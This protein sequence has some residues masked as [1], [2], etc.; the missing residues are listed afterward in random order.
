MPKTFTFH[1]I[2]DIRQRHSF[3]LL[4]YAITTVKIKK[5]HFGERLY[6]F[7]KS[8]NLQEQFWPISFF[9]LAFFSSVMGT[10]E[11]IMS[12]RKDFPKV[13]KIVGRRKLFFVQP[14]I[15]ELW[16]CCHREI[17][18][19]LRRLILYQI[20]RFARHFLRLP[21]YGKQHYHSIQKWKNELEM[22]FS[23]LK[24]FS[25]SW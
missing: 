3:S 25:S 6:F 2:T 17:K 12:R 15:T 23:V 4:V 24:V 18:L 10:F 20:W 22:F 8:R 16:C 1:S 21:H 9:F 19:W 5:S 14:I 13:D 11:A 7:R